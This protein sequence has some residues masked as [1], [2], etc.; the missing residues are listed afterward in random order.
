M[1][2]SMARQFQGFCETCAFWNRDSSA[3]AHECRRFPP[4]YAET[5]DGRAIELK[6]VWPKTP[7]TDWCGEYVSRHNRNR[8][9]EPET[10]MDSDFFADHRC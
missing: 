3:F 10:A 9:V 2:A 5:Q 4:Q 6:R 1:L 7:P 8:G